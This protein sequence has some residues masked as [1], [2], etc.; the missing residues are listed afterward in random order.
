MMQDEKTELTEHHEAEIVAS[1]EAK[2]LHMVADRT[3]RTATVEIRR[4]GKHLDPS[5]AG[6]DV[7]FD[8]S[9]RSYVTIDQGRMYRLIDD[10]AGYGRHRIHLRTMDKGFSIYALSFG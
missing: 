2:A 1:Y 5:I 4:D 9:G 10:P 8:A 7:Q 3:G 6:A